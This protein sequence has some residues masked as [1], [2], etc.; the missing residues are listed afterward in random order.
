MDPTAHR[1]T[2]RSELLD[3]LVAHSPAATMR[4]MRRWPGGALSLVHI[5]VMTVLDEDGPVAMRSL[6]ESLDVSQASA[7]GIVDRMEQR[8][9]VERR[10]DDEDRRVV[11]VALTE[12]GRTT[13]GGMATERRELLLEVLEDLTDEELSGF[14]L[15]ARAMRRARERLHAKLQAEHEATNPGVPFHDTPPPR[16]ALAPAPRTTR[17]TATTPESPTTHTLEAPR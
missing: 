8:G 1:T 13:I 4:Y 6:A 9:L 15:G 12:L 11:R 3:E 14:L 2:L 10:R 5:H 16:D 17:V 7:T